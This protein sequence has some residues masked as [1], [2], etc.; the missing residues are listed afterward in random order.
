M[1]PLRL[2][3]S[4]AREISDLDPGSRM[5]LSPALDAQ[6]GP[7]L[8]LLLRKLQDSQDDA[9][10]Q[11]TA[12]ASA[13]WLRATPSAANTLVVS[14]GTHS[15]CRSEQMIVWCGVNLLNLQ[16]IVCNTRP[17]FLNAAQRMRAF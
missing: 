8:C 7:V 17:C 10:R 15:R 16:W 2:L 9:E 5:A 1:L 4:I 3:Q 11:V 12:Q 13:L 14:P 6:V